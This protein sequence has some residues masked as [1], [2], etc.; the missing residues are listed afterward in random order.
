M[1]QDKIGKL[2][3]KKRKE[4]NM[5]QSELADKLCV[6][7]KTVSRWETGNYMP[8]LSM[9][10]SLSEL[11][12]ISTYELLKGEEILNIQFEDEELL[13]FKTIGDVVTCAEGKLK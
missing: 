3:A 8:D 4:L 12:N 11:L 13:S 9:I 10:V 6:T 7:N 2:I 5:T 1:N